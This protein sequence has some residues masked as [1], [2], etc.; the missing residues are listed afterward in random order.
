MDKV[1]VPYVRDDEHAGPKHIRLGGY[2][3]VHLTTS[4]QA[5]DAD[6]TEEVLNVRKKMSNS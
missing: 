2:T 1:I 4:N 6:N 3:Q 5:L